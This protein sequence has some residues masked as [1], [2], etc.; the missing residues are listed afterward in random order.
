MHI[1]YKQSHKCSQNHELITKKV[2]MYTNIICEKRPHIPTYR[3]K[4]LRIYIMFKIVFKYNLYTKINFIFLRLLLTIQFIFEHYSYNNYRFCIFLTLDFMS[5]NFFLVLRLFIS[6]IFLSLA[7]YLTRL[8]YNIIL[9][10]SKS[11]YN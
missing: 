7:L 1:I 4:C 10:C 6:K 5:L 8:F 3:A 2:N 11:I 9:F